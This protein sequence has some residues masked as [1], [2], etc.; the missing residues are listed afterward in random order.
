MSTIKEALER[1]RNLGFSK[2][3]VCITGSA[4]LAIWNQVAHERNY[5]PLLP[6]GRVIGD[7]DIYTS[8]LCPVF[9]DVAHNANLAAHHECGASDCLT[10][11]I[12][13]SKYDVSCQWPFLVANTDN[14]FDV[15]EE[16]GG[17]R[18]MTIGKIADC[19]R[20][21]GRQKDL[22]DLHQIDVA[23]GFRRH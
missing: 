19:K 17:I 3:Q 15:S 9:G 13:G 2:D 21:F 1:F 20:R 16:V 18:V 4:G 14:V 11:D 12:D 10:F 6:E 8:R 23:L 7:L 22:G 5:C